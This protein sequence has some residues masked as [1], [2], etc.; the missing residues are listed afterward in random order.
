MKI[1]IENYKCPSWNE[2]N[3]AIHWAVR[4][5]VRDEMKQLF[6]AC[7]YS[8]YTREE[9]KKM[10]AEL[11]KPVDVRIEAHF[12]LSNRRDPDNLFVKPILDGMVKAGIFTDDNGDVVNSL[13]LKATRKMPKD[14]II[15]YINE[16]L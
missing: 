4:S 5:A 1:E 6:L 13:T 15:I 2:S 7:M 16:N 8:Q 14:K 10:S 11:K 9:L 12:K 3:R